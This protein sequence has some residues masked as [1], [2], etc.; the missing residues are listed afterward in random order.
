MANTRSVA[1]TF[2]FDY[3]YPEDTEAASVMLN[4]L[5][6]LALLF[7]AY[8]DATLSVGW[9][10]SPVAAVGKDAR[11]GLQLHAGWCAKALI[12]RALALAAYLR[13]GCV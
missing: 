7:F 8:S 13:Y 4:S 5:P 6:I 11:S 12:R 1:V 10:E 9:T 2:D 3:G